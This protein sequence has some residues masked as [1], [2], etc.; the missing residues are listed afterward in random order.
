MD[1]ASSIYLYCKHGNFRVGPI[2]AFFALRLLRE[3]YPYAKIKPI[4]LYEGNSSIVKITPTWN[5][6]PTFSRNFPPAKITTFTVCEIEPRC[7][8]FSA[9]SEQY[10]ELPHSVPYNEN[11]RKNTIC[12]YPSGWLW[13]HFFY[14]HITLDECHAWFHWYGLSRD[15]RNTKQV[16]ISRSMSFS[17]GLIIIGEHN[18]WQT[19]IQLVTKIR[20]CPI[21]IILWN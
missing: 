5:V 6:L 12:R 8:L 1:K 17:I 7:H 18:L 9:C 2:F 14:A 20:I 21:C 16:K 11:N 19:D 4:C 10:E 3:N 15:M 13:R